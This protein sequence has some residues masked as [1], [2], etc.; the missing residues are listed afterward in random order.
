MHIFR[1]SSA[2]RLSHSRGGVNIAFCRD[3]LL[4]SAVLRL[5]DHKNSRYHA[6]LGVAQLMLS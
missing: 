2:L 4:H 1:T 5:L 3:A 6:G